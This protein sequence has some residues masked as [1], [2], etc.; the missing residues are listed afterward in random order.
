M[1]SA[2]A[3]AIVNSTVRVPI[4]CAVRVLLIQ[5]AIRMMA[6]KAPTTGAFTPPVK[7]ATAVATPQLPKASTYL[8]A[9]VQP[10]RSNSD[11]VSATANSSSGPS[12]R[13]F[14]SGA[15]K[16]KA[17]R[18][19]VEPANRTLM[20]YF[21]KAGHGSSEI[22]FL[23]SLSGYPGDAEISLIPCSLAAPADNSKRVGLQMAVMVQ[24][25]HQSCSRVLRLS[26]LLHRQQRVRG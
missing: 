13:P 24:D 8:V 2:V 19:A 7:M 5:A 9:S 11:A 26:N 6:G 25:G 17:S 4:T 22:Q 14:C 12:M 3:R 1:D 15:S 10:R 18:A 20:L 23:I 21:K 16:R